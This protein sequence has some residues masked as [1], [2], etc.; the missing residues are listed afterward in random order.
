MI[1]IIKSNQV[2]GDEALRIQ[3]DLIKNGVESTLNYGAGKIV[4]TGV[5]MKEMKER[6]SKANP[7]VVSDIDY[8]AAEIPT[9]TPVEKNDSQNKRT[10]KPDK[11]GGK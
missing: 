6:Y 3:I 7:I 11:P 9:S 10:S 2:F 5:F 4:D 1:I 8:G